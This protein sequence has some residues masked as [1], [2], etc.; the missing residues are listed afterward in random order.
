MLSR[1]LQRVSVRPIQMLLA[2]LLLAPLL[3]F[4]SP[5]GRPASS[6]VAVAGGIVTSPGGAAMAGQTVALYAWPS[7]AVLQALKPGQLVPTTLLASATTNS[8]GKYMLRVPVAKLK[9]AAVESGSANLEIFSA[10]GGFWFFPYQTGSLP[11][12]ASAPV[13]V[14]R[15]SD[16]GVKCGVDD[17][18]RPLAFTGFR[19]LKQLNPAWAVIGQGYIA[20]SRKTRHDNIQFNYNQT[21]TKSQSS[22]LGLGVSGYGVD[23]GYNHQGTDVSTATAGQGFRAQKESTWFRTLFNVA[24]FRGMCVGRNGDTTIHHKKQKGYCPRTY[25]PM[26]GFVDYVRK[27]FWMAR[28]TGWFGPSGNLQRP[29]A[30]QIPGTPAK[31]CGPEPAGGIAMTHNQ[32]GL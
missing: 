20:Q 10:V 19:K 14:P 26:P 25:K 18:N 17:L 13:T 5:P 7:D 22:T 4:S 28:S 23:A 1:A 15:S 32:A 9:A 27:C 2:A 29:T 31:F 8:A 6:G 24:K 3:A 11:G 21:T 12:R 16:L 30:R